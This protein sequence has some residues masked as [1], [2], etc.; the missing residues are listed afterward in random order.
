M[1]DVSTAIGFCLD[2][3][4]WV[5]TDAHVRCS[6]A[7][8]VIDKEIATGF[9]SHL[10]NLEAAWVR[11]RRS[12]V[13]F[14]GLRLPRIVAGTRRIDLSPTRAPQSGPSRVIFP[15]DQLTKM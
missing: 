1:P 2:A 14:V 6:P 5:P 13:A 15:A 3:C 11:I 10:P 4:A 9:V 7:P 12:S 8:S